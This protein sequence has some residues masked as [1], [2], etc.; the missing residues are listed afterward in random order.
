MVAATAFIAVGQLN[1][2]CSS[3][4]VVCFTY[5]GLTALRYV[6]ERDTCYNERWQFYLMCIYFSVEMGNGNETSYLTTS[7]LYF[8]PKL[9]PLPECTKVHH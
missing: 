7:E 4:L 5:D 1:R 9:V 3:T 6:T 2:K 8:L